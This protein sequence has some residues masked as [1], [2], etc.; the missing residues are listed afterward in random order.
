MHFSI[1]H[2]FTIYNK[3]SESEN[4]DVLCGI[5]E[6]PSALENL[7]NALQTVQ[8]LFRL[9]SNNSQSGK[10]TNAITE[11]LN[12]LS[13][14]ILS[15]V[16]SSNIL[17]T[18]TGPTNSNADAN[19]S[20]A[21]RKSSS[22]SSRKQ[23]S[24]TITIN[25]PVYNP[26]PILELKKFSQKNNEPDDVPLITQEKTLSGF[27]R[28]SELC[29][30]DDDNEN[31]E[32]EFAERILEQNESNYSD[33]KFDE[34]KKKK[35]VN[36]EEITS[37]SPSNSTTAV[38]VKNQEASVSSSQKLDMVSFAKLKPSQQLL[39]RYEMLNKPIPSANTSTVPNFK[40]QISNK[41]LQK[42]SSSN[43]T[44]PRLI[45]DTSGTLK[46]NSLKLFITFLCA[47]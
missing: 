36:S 40:K 28:K 35:K 44:V 22:P 1:L 38:T 15:S 45:M 7:S 32:N 34:V 23:K 43:P 29:S 20:S 2:N 18:T 24:A 10:T 25:A 3:E 4:N 14:T 19:S 26:T 5:N 6:L 12:N 8:D 41:D 11:Q 31:Y 30:N 13:S 33:N 39:K 9:N 47:I 17:K 27:K 46:V 21:I 42:N 37:S 16:A